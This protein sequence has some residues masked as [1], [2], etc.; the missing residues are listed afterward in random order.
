MDLKLIGAEAQKLR[1]CDR[2]GRAGADGGC[3]ARVRDRRDLRHYLAGDRRRAVCG[4]VGQPR[5]GGRDRP[6][7]PGPPAEVTG[8]ASF[9]APS[10]PSPARRRWPTCNDTPGPDLA[11]ALGDRD[12]YREPCL[13]QCYRRPA[14]FLQRAGTMTS[15]RPCP[16][17]AVLAA[18]DGD[19]GDDTRDS[20]P[21]LSSPGSATWI[22]FPPD[23]RAAGG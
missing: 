14:V 11:A 9:Y 5:C 18:L 7:P 10:R 13:G 20:S 12:D 15:C 23:Y 16:P 8:V 19:V 21:G 3:P 4:G 2:A 22:L 6:P 17:D 1:S